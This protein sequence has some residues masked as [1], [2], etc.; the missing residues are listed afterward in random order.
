MIGAITAGL[1]GTGMAVSTTS[2]DS[3]STVTVGAGGVSS[4]TFS[5]IPST[6]KHLQ[7]RA[8]H[9]TAAAGSSA[10]LR[11]NGDTTTS[12]Y[13]QHTL[14]GTG[15]AA[16]VNTIANQLYSPYDSG[17][18]ATTSPGA[19]VLD[20]LDY[21]DT[22]KYKTARYLS[23]YDANGSGIIQFVSGLWTSTSAISS[24]TFTL[25]FNQYSSFALYGI[26]G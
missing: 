16:G 4:I 18:A 9:V 24:I 22:N 23:G 2:Y 17:G 5:S 20:I 10:T 19:M 14:Y 1:F 3:I 8:L 13:R 7:I 15:A 12:N 6:Y 21:A 25:S 11:F 26:K